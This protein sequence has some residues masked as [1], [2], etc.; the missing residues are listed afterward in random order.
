MNGI[1]RVVRAILAAGRLASTRWSEVDLGWNAKW[2]LG[3]AV[4]TIPGVVFDE[5]FRAG[6]RG[7]A[8]RLF[9]TP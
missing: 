4:W 1:E 9:L 8:K 3:A 6:G 2:T 7:P 5:A